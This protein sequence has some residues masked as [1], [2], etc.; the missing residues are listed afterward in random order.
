MAG[1]D[2]A[3]AGS[4]AFQV[5]S[6]RSERGR[7]VWTLA[8]LGA[9][10]AI[11]AARSLLLRPEGWKEALA[12]ALLVGAPAIGYE[13]ALLVLVGR[14]LRRGQA[15]PAV[16]WWVST[17]VEALF[18][19]VVLALAGTVPALGPYGALTSPAVALYYLAVLLAALRLRPALCLL[20]GGVA[21][22]GYLALVAEAF[23]LNAPPP[24][25]AEHPA[26][27]A[28]SAAFMLVFGPAAAAVAARVR[29]YLAAALHEAAERQRAV[30]EARNVLI[31]GLAKLAEYRDTDTGAHL[32]RI[33]A[34]A[35]LLAEGL[36]GRV[37]QIDA[38][39]ID[40][41]RVASSMHDIG[42]V[43]IP[44]A[45]LLKPGRLTEDERRVI[46][47]HPGI[48]AETLRAIE[49]RHGEDPLLRMSDE[50]AIGHHE[51]WDGSG[52]PRQNAGEKISLAARIVS[53]VDVY[54]ALTSAR[55]YK[56][57]LGHDEALRIIREGRGTQFDPMIVDVFLELAD[58]FDE[59]RRGHTE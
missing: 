59:V 26:V 47:R 32:E 38:G 51:R 57:A 3:I 50:I 25:A 24:P 55:V 11:V 4:D 58:R 39:W 44:D 22:A 2:G 21:A 48:G 56:P 45:V 28:T 41:L 13:A 9:I 18:P 52:Y 54:D 8:A 19:S 27:Y 42:K 31:F 23:L 29:G 36:R 7:L 49:Q 15:L 16:F 33:S 10:V 37:P 12:L 35:A 53:V 30:L 6:A 5:E 43:G 34:Y 20:S 1:P 17:A 14:Y 46:E 40:T